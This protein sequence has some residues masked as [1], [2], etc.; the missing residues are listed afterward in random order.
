MVGR[1]RASAKKPAVAQKKFL[2]REDTRATKARK[3]REQ[4]LRGRAQAAAVAEDPVAASDELS[5]TVPRNLG[6]R[7]KSAAAPLSRKRSKS[8]SYSESESE[9]ESEKP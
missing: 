4:P 2:E 9:S 7:L 1:Y 5:P 3:S 8:E 6:S